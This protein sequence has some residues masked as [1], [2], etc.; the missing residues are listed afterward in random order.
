[1][2]L[3]LA[4]IFIGQIGQSKMMLAEAYD[5]SAGKVREHQCLDEPNS[6]VWTNLTHEIAVVSKAFE[7]KVEG[8]VDPSEPGG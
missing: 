1:M 2:W 5:I 3:A 8:R 6:R 4:A 7:I